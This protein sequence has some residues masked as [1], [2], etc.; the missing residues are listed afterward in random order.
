MTDSV[1]GKHWTT[2]EKKHE[3]DYCLELAQAAG[4]TIN[5]EDRYPRL[6]IPAQATS[7]IE[8][9]L[10]TAGVQPQRPL[11]ACHVSANNGQSKRWPVPYWATLLDRLIREEQANV[12]LTG[13]PGRSALDRE[14]HPTYARATAQS[15]G[16]NQPDPT[17]R[18]TQT[19]G[20]IDQ[21]VIVG[22]CTWRAR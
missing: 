18:S 20:F 4:A 7:E 15:R 2:G 22:R 10:A 1:P 13:A 3:V 21:R 12:V 8:Q 19:G 17:C 14:N 6:V 11:I 9:L 16:Q 5:A